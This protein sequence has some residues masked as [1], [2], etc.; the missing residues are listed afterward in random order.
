MG[1]VEVHSLPDGEALV[2]GKYLIVKA[3]VSGKYLIVEVG[4]LP[5]LVVLTLVPYTKEVQSLP[6]GEVLVIG[7][8]LKVYDN[9]SPG[10]GPGPR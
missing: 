2:P 1:K 5:D 10:G 9:S 6:D 3:L 8:Y 7:K 4:S